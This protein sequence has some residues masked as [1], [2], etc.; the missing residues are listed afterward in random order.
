MSDSVLRPPEPGVKQRELCRLRKVEPPR[1]VMFPPIHGNGFRPR[2]RRV[3]R[4]VVRIAAGRSNK[5]LAS[6]DEGASSKDKGGSSK[7]E[8]ASSKDK[9]ASSKDEG[10]SSK[11]KGASSTTKSLAPKVTAA[12]RTTEL[13]DE[14]SVPRTLS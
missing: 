8:G 4:C 11:D 12:T 13:P 1:R 9:E 10:G 5:S 7:D 3:R 6:K 2:A 14:K